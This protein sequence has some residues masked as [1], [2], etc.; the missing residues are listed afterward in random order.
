MSDVIKT[1]KKNAYI[2]KYKYI[3]FNYIVNI[4]LTKKMKI[5]LNYKPTTQNTWSYFLIII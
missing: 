4:L 2:H 5:N 3:K 1:Y